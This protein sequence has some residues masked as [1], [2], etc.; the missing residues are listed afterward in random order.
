LRAKEPGGGRVLLPLPRFQ[1]PGSHE[2]ETG[3]Q[4]Q[5]PMISSAP[6]GSPD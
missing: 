3:F 5:D 6:A 1:P 4:V 2:E